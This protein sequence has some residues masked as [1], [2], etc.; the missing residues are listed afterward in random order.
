[1]EEA[2]QQILILNDE[3]R[4]SERLLK[5][6]LAGVGKGKGEAEKRLTAALTTRQKRGGTGHSAVEATGVPARTRRG[7]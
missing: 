4:A 3:L 5:T 2:V 1:M 7:R 6:E